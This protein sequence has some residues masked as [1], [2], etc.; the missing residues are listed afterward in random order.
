MVSPWFRVEL[1]IGERRREE[2]L[3]QGF[4][5]FGREFGGGFKAL[6]E[7]SSK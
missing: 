3:R 2:I 4:V 5:R 1:E 6:G 7:L